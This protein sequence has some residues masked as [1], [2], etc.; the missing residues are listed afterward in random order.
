LGEISSKNV[1]EIKIEEN[2]NQGTTQ[3]DGS[4]KKVPKYIP[5]QILRQQLLKENKPQ[6]EKNQKISLPK[7]EEGKDKAPA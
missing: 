1:S 3:E 5:P 6:N 4:P 7:I 2:T